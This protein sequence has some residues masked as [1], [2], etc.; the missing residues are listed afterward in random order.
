M[1]TIRLKFRK[2][3]LSIYY[4]QLDLQRVMARALKK[5]GLP[6]WYSQGF[7]PHIYMTFTLPL[8]LG[9]ESECESVDFRLN[10]EMAEADILKALEGTLPQGIELVSAQAPDYDARSIMF[11]KYD[12]TLYG[13]SKNIINALNSYCALEQ[14]V[15]TKTTKKGQKDINLKELI[16]DIIVTD[17]K[18]NEVT[19][20]AIYP[21]GT[22]LNINPQLLL[23]FLKDNY[24][25]EIID[26]FIIRKNLFDKDMNILQ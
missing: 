2:K 17:E 13:E 7:N 14:A 9:H 19:F 1:N 3:G 22:P 20:T 6:V 16:K 25:I 11:A 15:V 12:I 8:S 24:G 5:S 4:S 18:E 26:A 21:A 23:D 10:E